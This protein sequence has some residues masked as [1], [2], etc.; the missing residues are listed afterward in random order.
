MKR[1][2]TLSYEDWEGLW[3]AGYGFI[4]KHKKHFPGDDTVSNYG[5][6]GGKIVKIDY[7]Q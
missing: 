7:G 5:I 6:L 4:D 2:Q 1:A 3:A